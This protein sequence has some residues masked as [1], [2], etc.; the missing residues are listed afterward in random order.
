MMSRG[1]GCSDT[2]VMSRGSGCSYTAVM[3]RGSGCSKCES[4]EIYGNAEKLIN[5]L[6]LLWCRGT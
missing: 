4:C 6:I 1:S 5:F 2:A 3:S